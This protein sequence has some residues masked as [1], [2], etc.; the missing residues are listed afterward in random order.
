MFFAWLPVISI[1]NLDLCF[2]FFGDEVILSLDAVLE[3]RECLDEIE[4]LCLNARLPPPAPLGELSALNGTFLE[5]D[6]EKL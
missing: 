3:A 2:G 6:D 5:N 4:F 1:M